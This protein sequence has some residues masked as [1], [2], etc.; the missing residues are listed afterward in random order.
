MKVN[1]FLAGFPKCGTT[2]LAGWLAQ[3]RGVSVSDPKEPNHFSGFRDVRRLSDAEYSS[4]FSSRGGEQYFCDATPDYLYAPH[5]LDAMHKHNPD[6]LVLVLVRDH[7]DMAFSL[8]Q[9]ELYNGNESERD[10]ERAWRLSSARA[11]GRQVPGSCRE[12]LRLD[13]ARRLTL[14]QQLAACVERFGR[15]QVL[16]L[17]FDMLRSEPERLW[18]E[19]LDFLGLPQQDGIDF[20]AKNPRKELTNLFLLGL[21]KRLYDVKRRLRL[22]TRLSIGQ[23]LRKMGSRP[24]IERPAP[25]EHLAREIREAYADDFALL[26]AFANSGPHCLS[27]RLAT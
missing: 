18:S 7:V 1:L 8:H 4:G 12:P 21:T 24:A 19:L 6:A 9:Q 5:S 20:S 15:K 10:F 2:S 3:H 11:E 25:P 26:R 16:V 13:Y 17:D 27:E 14:G 23:T 22:N